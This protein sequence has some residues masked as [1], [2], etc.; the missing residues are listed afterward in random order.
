MQKRIT[1]S[2]A[3]M[4]FA[5]VI[6]GPAAHADGPPE[7]YDNGAPVQ[8]SLQPGDYLVNADG[9]KE[10]PS[11]KMSEI[12]RAYRNGWIHRGNTDDRIL[13]GL[14]RKHHDEQVAAAR[15]APRPVNAPRPAVRRYLPPPPPSYADVP[16]PG[17]YAPPMY[18]PA[19]PPPVQPV[20][21]VP[22]YAPPPPP[23]PPVQYVPV[24]Q[25]P[26]YQQPVYAPPGVTV[27]TAYPV[28][29]GYYG[30]PWWYGGGYRR[31]RQ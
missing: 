4:A 23:V 27:A 9:A 6:Y 19:P 17:P 29:Q 26:A 24:Y 2:L 12:A 22:V 14:I 8:R 25:Q 28:V 30:T 13:K 11:A 5:T 15:A 31:W 7:A 10:D 3:G 16:P 1:R 20:Q 21:Y 18:A